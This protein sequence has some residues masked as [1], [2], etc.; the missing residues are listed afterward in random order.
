MEP[1][2]RIPYEHAVA[3]AS[4]LLGQEAYAKAWAE[5]RAMSMEEAVEYALQESPKE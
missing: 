2:D 4:S 5:G 3:T 1:H